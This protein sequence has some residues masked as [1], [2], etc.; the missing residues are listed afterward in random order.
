MDQR[1]HVAATTRQTKNL[2]LIVTETT[3]KRLTFFPQVSTGST[4][5]SLATVKE[6][7]SKIPSL[8]PFF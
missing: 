7:A 8:V 6:Y 4:P 3:L 5:T 1:K 2:P